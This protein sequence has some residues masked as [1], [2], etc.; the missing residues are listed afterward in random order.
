MIKRY[1]E[2]SDNEVILKP[3]KSK[4]SPKPQKQNEAKKSAKKKAVKPDVKKQF[5]N[6]NLITTIEK[7][8][9]PLIGMPEKDSDTEDDNYENILPL[10]Q[11]K[12]D[13]K[14]IR[15]KPSMEDP[16]IGFINNIITSHRKQDS[17]GN[18]D[19]EKEFRVESEAENDNGS[20]ESFLIDTRSPETKKKQDELKR[21]AKKK[22]KAEENLAEGLAD[23]AAEEIEK[24]TTY[25]DSLEPD[26]TANEAMMKN[27]PDSKKKRSSLPESENIGNRIAGLSEMEAEEDRPHWKDAAKNRTHE[28]AVKYYGGDANFE[29]AEMQ[30]IKDWSFDAQR[31]DNLKKPSLWRRF[32][33][34]T[35]VGAGKLLKVATAILTGGFSGSCG[36][37][38]DPLMR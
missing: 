5:A 2:D 27:F 4:N 22:Q 28:M 36:A 26:M 9:A 14:I 16:A 11:E 13:R 35:A 23:I 30:K 6:E 34:R 21:K 33:T 7:K 8:K 31:M 20:E 12:E 37:K 25:D 15:E 29:I 32:L 24:G 38:T 18:S 10:I 3:A 17:G 19:T 1:D